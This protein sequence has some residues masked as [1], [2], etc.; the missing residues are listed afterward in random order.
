MPTNETVRVDARGLQRGC[1][2][3]SRICSALDMI[4]VFK[5]GSLSYVNDDLD[6]MLEQLGVDDGL[7]SMS[8]RKRKAPVLFDALLGL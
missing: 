8:T 7:P 6:A 2:P 5:A 4:E 3:P 1:R